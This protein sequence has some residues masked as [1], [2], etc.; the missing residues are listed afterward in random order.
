MSKAAR[1]GIGVVILA[2]ALVLLGADLRA[3]IAMVLVV[4]A[5]DVMEGT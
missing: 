2:G 4:I 5:T 1:F 3:L